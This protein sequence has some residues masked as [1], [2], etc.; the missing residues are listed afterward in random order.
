MA[1]EPASPVQA[2]CAPGAPPASLWR[3]PDFLRLWAAQ[4]ISAYGSRITR[5]ALPII[6][7]KTLGEPESMLGVLAALQFAPGVA[8]AVFAGGVVDRS[9]KRRV[10]IAADLVRAALVAS[11]TLA[12]ALGALSMLHVLLVGAGVGAASAVFQI[13]DVAYLPALVGRGQLAEGNARLEATE[14]VAE[15]TGPGSGGALISALGAPLA[16][17]LDAASYV[18]SALWLARIRAPEPS[19]PAPAS[20]PRRRGDDLRVGLRAVFGHPQVRP[21]VVGHMLWAVSGGFFMSLYALFCLRELRLSETA[22]GVIVAVGGIGALGGAVVSRALVRRLGLGPAL[23]VAST[24]SLACG[25][26]IPLAAGPA[27]AVIGLLVAHQLFGDGFSVA[28][29]V[30]AVTLRQTVLPRDVLGRAN[31]AIYVCTSGLVPVAALAAGAIAQL[32]GIR[33]AVWVGVLLGLGVPALLWPLRGLRAMPP[34]AP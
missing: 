31:A 15:I 26:F 28:Y 6:A 21:L 10:L 27:P 8:L 34:P 2:G 16:V 30:Q 13:A 17:A 29:T 20:A 11:L 14:A 9:R 22:Y 3:H 7:V 19:P 12:W 1:T 4:A 33:A 23:L 32:A 25:L 5:T 18:W 24:L